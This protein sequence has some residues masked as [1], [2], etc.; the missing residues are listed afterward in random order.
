MKQLLLLLCFLVSGVVNAQVRELATSSTTTLTNA[1]TTD[2]TILSGVKKAY[3][4][5]VL[6]TVDSLTGAADGFVD[7]Q[8]SNDATG[9]RWH[10]LQTLTVTGTQ[11]LAAWEGTLRARY[12]RLRYRSTTGSQTFRVYADLHLTDQAYSYQIK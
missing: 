6:I 2:V 4:Y 10:T 3:D 5:S 7:L 1:D 8:V 9:A 12:M 11:V